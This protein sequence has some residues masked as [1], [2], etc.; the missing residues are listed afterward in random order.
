MRRDPRKRYSDT[1]AFEWDSPVGVPFRGLMPRRVRRQ[2]GFL[3]YEV[4]GG[5]RLD[6]LAKYFYDD[7]RLWWVI[8]EANPEILLPADLIYAAAP[9]AATGIARLKAGTRIVIPARPAAP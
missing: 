6:A 8:V 1:P 3:D 2:T 9:E 7:E 5:D 4:K